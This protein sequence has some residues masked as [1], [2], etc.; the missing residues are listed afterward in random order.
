MR[1]LRGLLRCYADQGRTVLIASHLLA[2]AAQIVDEVIVL[3][4]GRLLAHGPTSELLARYCA[5]DLEELYLHL[6]GTPATA[7]VR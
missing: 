6:I 4:R 3:G 2:E 1:W 5:A 7:D